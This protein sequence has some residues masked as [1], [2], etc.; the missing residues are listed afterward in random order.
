MTEYNEENSSDTFNIDEYIPFQ[1]VLTEMLMYRVGKPNLAAE[2]AAVEPLSQGE[3][4]VLSFIYAGKASSPSDLIEHLFIDKALVT[5][6]V[7]SLVKKGLLEVSADESDKRRKNL[8]VSPK[9]ERSA[10]AL[11]ALMED[12]ALHVDSCIEKE[13]KQALMET[14]AKL[15]KACHSY[16]KKSP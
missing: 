12:F 13:E 11:V 14:L 2:V 8:R 10:K 15:N 1:I 3:S 16:Q 6:N 4:R 7:A 9:G 5:R